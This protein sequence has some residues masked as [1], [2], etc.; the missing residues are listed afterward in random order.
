MADVFI[1]Q[2]CRIYS[3]AVLLDGLNQESATHGPPVALPLYFMEHKAL[4]KLL[5]CHGSGGEAIKCLGLC[6]Q[7]I[8]IR[9][10]SRNYDEMCTLC[11]YPVWLTWCSM[12]SP[13]SPKVTSSSPTPKLQFDT[14]DFNSICRQLLRF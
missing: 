11:S 10:H 2:Y 6:Q 3:T 9:L 4:S 14:D 12:Q 7:T 8:T 13:D 1:V 5:S